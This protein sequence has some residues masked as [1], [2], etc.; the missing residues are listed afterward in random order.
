MIKDKIT[1]IALISFF[2][3]IVIIFS[4]ELFYHNDDKL[5]QDIEKNMKARRKLINGCVLQKDT[6]MVNHHINE[7]LDSQK[8]ILELDSN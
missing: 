8:D 6:A 4:V 7:L 3:A 1:T 2:V 5:K